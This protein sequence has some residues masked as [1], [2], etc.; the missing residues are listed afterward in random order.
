MVEN[1][2]KLEKHNE[3]TYNNNKCLRNL[4]ILISLL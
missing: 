1:E 2:K 4:T 3:I